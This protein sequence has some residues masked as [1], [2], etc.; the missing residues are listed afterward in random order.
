[1]VIHVIQGTHL[2]CQKTVKSQFNCTWIECSPTFVEEG[3]IDL[4]GFDIKRISVGPEIVR[5][6]V[7]PR[8]EA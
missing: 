8:T 5:V 6:F 1:M 2:L 4:R 3:E 7:R